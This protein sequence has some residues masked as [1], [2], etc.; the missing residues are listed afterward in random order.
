MG[1]TQREMHVSAGGV[2]RAAQ[3]AGQAQV[4]Q[5]AQAIIQRYQGW[6]IYWPS[7]PFVFNL[8][9]VAATM[10]S[11]SHHTQVHVAPRLALTALSQPLGAGRPVL[12][13]GMLPLAQ[14]FVSLLQASTSTQR[15]VSRLITKSE[16]IEGSA[17]VVS[18][19]RLEQEIA[20]GS[21][22]NTPPRAPA[23]PPVPRIVHRPAPTVTAAATPPPTVTPRTAGNGWEGT[24]T[25]RAPLRS[26][27][28]PMQ[29]EANPVDVNRLTEQVIQAIDR[30]II[31][32]RERL[33]RI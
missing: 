9:R 33:G 32:Q 25:G 15:L 22:G 31:A 8:K 5:F 26:P 2:R 30:R 23:V 1:V 19:P 10:H 16:R 6:C 12:H 28:M 7:L 13:Q 14:R 4:T 21:T 29:P 17:G 11:V 27:D 18:H 24:A 20:T 3:T